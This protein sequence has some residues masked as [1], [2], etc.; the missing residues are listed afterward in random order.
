MGLQQEGMDLEKLIVSLLMAASTAYAQPVP[1]DMVRTTGRIVQT[2]R[3]WLA[4]WPGVHW[5]LRFSG[6]ALAV[7]LDDSVNHWVLELDG[8]PALQ[9]PPEPGERTVWLRGLVPGA[10]EARLIKRTESS[11]RAARVVGFELGG[12]TLLPPPAKQP[13][14]EF[15][16]D[17][18]TAAMGNLSTERRCSN[19]EIAARTDTSQ[20]YAVLSARALGLDWRIH[21][22]SG[23]GLLRN[24]DGSRPG[25]THGTDYARAL[26]DRM[27][28]PEAEAP[29]QAYVIALGI[30]DYSTPVKP[31]EPRDAA[32]LDADFERS[33]AE[34]IARVRQR[35][36]AAPIVLI[37]APLRQG[38]KLRPAVARIAA[39]QQD[40]L[41]QVLDWGDI[42]GQGCG[43]H[44]DLKDH[45]QMAAKLTTLLRQSLP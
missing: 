22:R 29:A 32:Q 26:Q 35:S 19:E 21:A 12:S 27:G 3:G 41:L 25:E 11:G 7:R 40:P 39:A 5:T 18:F 20:G 36:P 23:A 6:Q 28:A 13:Y 43:G 10:H 17:S 31:G 44:P 45:Q 2:D 24:W 34:L 38:D 37:T 15:I 1:A 16:G 30:N 14:V 9:I 42:A 4:T 33:Y 8:K